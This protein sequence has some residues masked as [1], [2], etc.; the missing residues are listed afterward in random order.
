MYTAMQCLDYGIN[1]P[2]CT[3]VPVGADHHEADYCDLY[4]LWLKTKQAPTDKN[5]EQTPWLFIWDSDESVSLPVR[6]KAAVIQS[7]DAVNKYA[8]CGFPLLKRKCQIRTLPVTWC[9]VAFILS[10]FFNWSSENIL[11]LDHIFNIIKSLLLL[12]E[13]SRLF[14]DL[15]TR[16]S[17][18]TAQCYR[19]NSPPHDWW[20]YIQSGWNLFIIHVVCTL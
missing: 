2:I 16:G 8:S 3:S 6:R 9:T 15:S 20:L 13:W 17:H 1:L 5:V 11:S 4:C 12:Q 19:G 18:L 7:W 14:G 10:V